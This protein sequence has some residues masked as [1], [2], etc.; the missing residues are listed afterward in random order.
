MPTPERP[1]TVTVL[2]RGPV[3]YRWERRGPRTV[4]MLHGG[5]MR[6]SL[7]IHGR[8]RRRILRS[9]IRRTGAQ[10]LANRAPRAPR[11]GCRLSKC[12][13]DEAMWS[14][15]PRSD[16]MSYRP[17]RQPQV[18]ACAVSPQT[19]SWRRPGSADATLRTRFAGATPM[20]SSAPSE[21]SRLGA[22]ERDRTDDA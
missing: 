4:L 5:H 11:R 13:S 6:A 3:E 9:G 2:S 14:N 22:T 19:S 20:R 10:A 7:P 12:L 1:T 18:R 21:K 17:I 8:R 15:R 16:R